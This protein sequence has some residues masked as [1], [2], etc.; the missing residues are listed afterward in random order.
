MQSREIDLPAL[1]AAGNNDLVPMFE[2]AQHSLLIQLNVAALTFQQVNVG[3]AKF[4]G[5]RDRPV[6]WLPLNQANRHA[7]L[8]VSRSRGNRL[9]LDPQLRLPRVVGNDFARK[10]VT[11]AVEYFYL[12]AADE[13][14]HSAQVVRAFSVEEQLLVDGM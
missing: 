5:L 11:G 4:C 8:R 10:D 1:F 7:P 13:A 3:S 12:V 2:F 14:Q 6:H 9:G